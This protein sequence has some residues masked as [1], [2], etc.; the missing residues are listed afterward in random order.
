MI[1]FHHI[2]TITDSHFSSMAML[3]K[4]AFPPEQRRSLDKLEHEILTSKHFRA[5]A[6][7]MN[8]EFV[9]FFNYWIFETFY[10]VEHFAI[11]PELRGEKLGSKVLNTFKED[12]AIPV[13]IE[14]EMPTSAMA[15]RRIEFYE[16]AGF[17]TIPNDYA[18]PPYRPSDFMIP[19]FIMTNDKEFVSEHFDHIKMT[20]YKE[21]Y[22]YNSKDF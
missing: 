14:V 1:K 21:V 12:I 4:S 5:Y 22:H 11:K 8:G 2:S 7:L 20:L 9:G 10:F 6:L 17:H 16:K 15:K 3:Y 13:V 18:Q 19:M